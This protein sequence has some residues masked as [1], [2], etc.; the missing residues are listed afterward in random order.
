MKL[1]TTSAILDETAP[2]KARQLYLQYLMMAASGLCILAMFYTSYMNKVTS[3]PVTVSAPQ[4]QGNG[5]KPF[6]VSGTAGT[7]STTD[8]STIAADALA[9]KAL[10]TTAEQT[11]LQ[12]TYTTT[13]ARKWSNLPCGSSCRNG[14][15]Y[16][17]MTGAKYDAAMQVICDALSNLAENGAAENYQIALAE[18]WLHANGGGSGY[19]STLRWMAF[20]GTPS[21]TGAWMLQFG[22]HH[23]AANIAFRDGH[24]VGATPF[25]MG[26]EPKSFT[27]AG[28]TYAPLNSEKDGFTNMLASLSA[29][30]L[31]SAKI[32]GSFSD[33]YMIPGETQGGHAAFPAK[34]GLICSGLSQAQKDMVLAAIENY[35]GDMDS[36]THAAM[37]ALYASEIDNTYVGW[38][39]SG[40]SGNASSFM[41]AQGNYGRIDGPHVWVEFSCQGGIVVPGQ[42]HYHTVWRDH[43]H[44][45][46]QDLSGPA[47][48]TS[49]VTPLKLMS[50]AATLENKVPVLRWLT[51]NEEN[52]SHFQIEQSSNPSK[53]YRSIG[54]VRAKNIA[55]ENRYSYT[56]EPLTAAVSYFRLKMVDLDGK[57]TYSRVVNLYSGNGKVRVINTL[58]TNELL[59]GHP[60]L[61]TASY[62]R[63]ANLQGQ[64]VKRG[65]LQKGL[66]VTSINVGTI[67]TG[68]YV[69]SVEAGN[70][71][72]S[73]KFLKQ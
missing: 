36:A 48:D 73:A 52:V 35:T 65:Q 68:E 53:D 41:T 62:F 33:C 30:Q 63:V 28:N 47:I 56:S 59:V 60:S 44:D 14:V 2:S 21:A 70:E 34:A 29:S 49:M 7:Q 42:I 11:S 64:V 54:M 31:T 67:Q 18:A 19:D 8:V 23:Y 39:G 66:T 25:F 43:V 13:L 17:A 10:C 3:E 37:Q 71:K 61:T 20:L 32:S 72:I 16:G 55:G 40:T 12:L 50:F 4:P 51:A 46:G 45:Y 15:Q 5:Q 69:I 9:F 27:Y 58:V 24:V 22:Q 57:V 38:V 26:V 1:T 6:S